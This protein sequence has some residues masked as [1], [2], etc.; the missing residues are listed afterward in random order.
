MSG[1]RGC[2]AHRNSSYACYNFSIASNHTY[3]S[4]CGWT[5]YCTSIV[6]ATSIMTC[7][8]KNLLPSPSPKHIILDQ[9]ESIECESRQEI[10]MSVPR[11]YDIVLCCNIMCGREGGGVGE[12]GVRNER[13][14]SQWS[15]M[16]KWCNILSIHRPGCCLLWG[17]LTA[18][19][20]CLQNLPCDS[21]PVIRTSSL[22]IIDPDW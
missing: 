13:G 8:G 22:L 7:I 17:V 9:R 16:V 19:L 4:H 14:M 21:S 11:T 3:D 2:G 12:A 5:K 10:L 18:V 20:T 1:R 15:M 6:F